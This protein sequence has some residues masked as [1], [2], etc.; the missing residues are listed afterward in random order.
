MTEAYYI[1]VTRSSF[2]PHQTLITL[3]LNLLS[4]KV[5][6]P[7][8]E[9][10]ISSSVVRSSSAITLYRK[11]KLCNNFNVKFRNDNVIH[12]EMARKNNSNYRVMTFDT[13]KL[14]QAPSI[15][16]L[17]YFFLLLLIYFYYSLKYSL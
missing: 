6:L 4:F 16:F 12:Q 7:F 11:L 17:G 9:E 3:F 2:K 8:L 13:L 15:E 5:P 14:R 1:L 10:R